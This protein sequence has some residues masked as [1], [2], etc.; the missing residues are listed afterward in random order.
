MPGQIRQIRA[1]AP[2]AGHQFHGPRQFKNLPPA[3]IPQKGDH[4]V[5][6]M[7]GGLRIRRSGP[8]GI[9]PDAMLATAGAYI[10]ELGHMFKLG[11]NNRRHGLTILVKDEGLLR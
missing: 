4:V 9:R 5:L 3:H 8:T 11:L 6:K 7:L 1:V 2:K 10:L